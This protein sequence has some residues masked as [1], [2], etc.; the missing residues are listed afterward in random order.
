MEWHG[1]CNETAQFGGM[2]SAFIFRDWKLS[3]SVPTPAPPKNICDQFFT[4]RKSSTIF[5]YYHL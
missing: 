4:P 2:K 5:Y 3:K 1:N